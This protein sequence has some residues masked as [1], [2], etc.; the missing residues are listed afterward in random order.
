MYP[1]MLSVEGRD[2]LVVGGGGVALRKVTGLLAEGARVTVVAPETVA[3]LDALEDEARIRIERRAY[4]GGEAAG[5]ALVFAATADREVNRRVSEDARRAGVW[6]NVADDP[7]LCSFH[8]PAR[9]RRGDLQ[10]AIGSGGTAPFAVRHLRRLLERRL[11]EEW[12]EWAAAAA[13]FRRAV[14]AAGLDPGAER[15]CWETW[16]ARTVDPERL[17]ARV[18]TAAETAEWI[19]RRDGDGAGRPGATGPARS[20]APSGS[21]DGGWVSLVGAGPGAPDLVTLRGWRRLHEADVIVYDR[22]A[23]GAL[24]ADL[25]PSVELRPV[26]KTAGRHPVPQPE[27]GAMLVRLAAEGRRVVRLKGGDPFVFGRGGEEA[28]AL[29]RAGIPFEVIP[30][31]TAGIA[32]PAWAGI[33]V[34]SRGQAVRVT[35]VTAHECNKAGG[36]QVRWD[37]IASDPHATV[38]GYMG[39]SSLPRVVERLLAAG[40]D[41]GTPAAMIERATTA[42]QRVALA[43]VAKL[44][45][46]AREQGIRPPAVFVIGPGV[47]RRER[48]DWWAKTPLAGQRLLLPSSLTRAEGP[49]SRSGA[50]VVI[51]PLPPTPAG[52]IAIAA[53]PLTGCVFRTPAEVD[54]L[55]DERETPGLAGAPVAW[56]L[57]PATAGRAR[58]RGWKPVVELAGRDPAGELVH[59]I[60]AIRVPA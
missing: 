9:I 25:P 47:A 6:V 50:E 42:G 1:V 60:T 57:G 5:Y 28:D 34:T 48:L 30:G 33:P 45:Q 12:S 13:S 32:G 8:L 52:R 58:E 49:L 21:P 10:L 19:G 14:R 38:V 18:P 36:P 59:A 26:G 20:G 11:G 7:E 23:A 46:E 27:I 55:E 24:P 29:A 17:H 15:E 22:L 40:L 43:P 44:P 54:L 37:L 56:C 51:V 53:A 39:V 35:L 2:C 41:P 16:F 31:V 4:R 3:E